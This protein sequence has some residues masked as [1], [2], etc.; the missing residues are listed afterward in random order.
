MVHSKNRKLGSILRIIY[1]SKK[2]KKTAAKNSNFSRKKKGLNKAC[3]LILLA[4]SLVRLFSPLL[5]PPL[6]LFAIVHQLVLSLDSVAFKTCIGMK[7]AVPRT[8]ATGGQSSLSSAS[9]C[10]PALECREKTH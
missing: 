5:I 3:Q 4:V 6:H 10:P 2:K 8:E 1:Q 9:S 7:Q